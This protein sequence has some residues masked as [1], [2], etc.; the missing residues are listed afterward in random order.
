MLVEGCEFRN[1]QRLFLEYPSGVDEDLERG[2]VRSSLAK[3]PFGWA[4]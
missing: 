2:R 1:I 4:L 3:E